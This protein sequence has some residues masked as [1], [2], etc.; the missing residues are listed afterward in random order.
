M[1]KIL[2]VEDELPMARSLE[3]KLVNAGFATKIASNG[4]EALAIL[5]N[6]KFDLMFL[7]LI[8]PKM[9]G[10]S[11]LEELKTR[12]INMPVVVTSNLKQASDVIEARRLGA[13]DYFVKSD[14]ALANIVS[15]TKKLLLEQEID[16]P[17]IETPP[18]PDDAN[19]KTNNS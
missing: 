12:N 13:K 7:D 18:S 17:E 6:E 4:E 16:L 3:L 5:N 1:P 15:Y 2:I 9:N 14:T 8:M 10:F 19:A 11:V